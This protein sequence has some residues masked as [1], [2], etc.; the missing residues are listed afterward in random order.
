MSLH[1]LGRDIVLTQILPKLESE[2]FEKIKKIAD[3]STY[4]LLK[5]YEHIEFLKSHGFPQFFIVNVDSKM[6]KD[7]TLVRDIENAMIEL[8]Q[9]TPH[10]LKI[11]LD[12]KIEPYWSAFVQGSK[13]FWSKFYPE[14]IKV[15]ATKKKKEIFTFYLNPKNKGEYMAA[16]GDKYNVSAI[17]EPPRFTIYKLETINGDL[18]DG[19]DEE[20]FSFKILNGKKGYEAVLNNRIELLT[21]SRDYI[22]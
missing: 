2:D 22:L 17:Y 5:E 4:K 15:Q 18:F 1:E 6:Q 19:D 11:L 10:L 14:E 20:R 3:K 13:N 12:K 8:Q 9:E 21:S 16:W 7:N